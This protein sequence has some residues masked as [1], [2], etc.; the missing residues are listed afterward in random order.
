[1][2]KAIHKSTFLKAGPLHELETCG[3]GTVMAPFP[4]PSKPQ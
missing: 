2:A 3:S 4:M 1:M